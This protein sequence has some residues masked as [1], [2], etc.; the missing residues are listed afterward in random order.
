MY[1]AMSK[2]VVRHIAAELATHL[3]NLDPDDR[4][5]CL[6]VLIGNLEDVDRDQSPEAFLD[7]LAMA[8]EIRLREGSW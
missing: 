1:P 8:L 7:S 5:A 4:T 6:L 3:R 2:P